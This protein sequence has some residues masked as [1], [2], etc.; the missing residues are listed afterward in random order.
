MNSIGNDNYRPERKPPK[1]IKENSGWLSSN[2]AQLMVFLNGL[3]LTITAFA[4][5]NV[6]IN[7][8][9]REELLET[10][11]K[12]QEQIFNEFEQ[13]EKSINA[14]STILAQA[15]YQENQAVQDFISSEISDSGHF[16]SLYLIKNNQVALLFDDNTA[17]QTGFRA[18]L[19]ASVNQLSGMK[20]NSFEVF[21]LNQMINSEPLHIIAKKQIVVNQE[22]IITA[23]I[24]DFK[25]FV[26]LAG[27]NE[28][29]TI[30]Q[31][32]IIDQETGDPFFAYQKKHSKSANG[33]S[34][35]SDLSERIIANK[36]IGIEVGLNMGTRESFLQKI[37]LLMLLFGVT[38]TLIGTLYVRNNQ[39]QS[40]KLSTVNKE[41]AHKNFELNQQVSE[42]ERLNDV[43]QKSAK[44]HQTIINAVSDI[45][46]ELSDKG[47]IQFLNDAWKT[48]TAPLG[49]VFLI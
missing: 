42:R 9:V 24:F 3:I 20:N 16:H 28:Y 47:K 36:N 5:L 8:I 33:F 15:D 45:I 49:V 13:A 38:L 14:L 35:Y 43:I 30:Q 6:F 41:L 10:T 37:P 32:K 29:D 11:S 1:P 18:V 4:T 31:V 17:Q 44:E 27:S 26:S 12:V 19:N 7:E 23:A 21:P 25:S 22:P 34:Q 2:M 46:V 48:V 40:K 39:M